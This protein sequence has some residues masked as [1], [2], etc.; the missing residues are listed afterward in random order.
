[1]NL[2]LSSVREYLPSST[3]VRDFS[4]YHV[5]GCS[6]RYI[7]IPP[8]INPAGHVSTYLRAT[9]RIHKRA[10]PSTIK[11]KSNKKQR[12]VDDV[13][14]SKRTIEVTNIDMTST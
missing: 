12:E 9:E 13:D 11:D 4:I 1:M 2:T 8:E 3:T 14:V 10:L 7:H 6:I 5:S